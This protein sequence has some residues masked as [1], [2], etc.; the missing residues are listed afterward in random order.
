MAVPS[1]CMCALEAGALCFVGIFEW[2]DPRH[3][4]RSLV[5]LFPC[6]PNDGVL[7]CSGRDGVEECPDDQKFCPCN[8]LVT[9]RWNEAILYMH[10]L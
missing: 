9:S 6:E 7:G 4:Q 1:P 5:I 8:C 2:L 3:G 10:D